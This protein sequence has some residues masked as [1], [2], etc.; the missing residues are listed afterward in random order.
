MRLA[1]GALIYDQNNR[2]IVL[3]NLPQGAD[4]VYAKDAAG[5]LTRIYILTDLEKARLSALGQ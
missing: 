1:P 5:N 4:V 2:T 3:S